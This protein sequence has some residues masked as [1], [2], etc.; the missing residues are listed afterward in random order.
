MGARENR[1]SNH[2]G[3][4]LDRSLNNLFRRLM[5][6]RIDHFDAGISQGARDNF[7]STVMAVK[8]WLCYY[9]T[10]HIRPEFPSIATTSLDLLA[11][12]ICG[13]RSVSGYR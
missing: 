11:R 8:P 6:T 1:E 10:T 13:L 2:V 5:E 9:N 3:I 4:L 12:H 7:G